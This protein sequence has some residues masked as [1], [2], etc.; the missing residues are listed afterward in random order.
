VEPPGAHLQRAGR[1]ADRPN[2][3]GERNGWVDDRL[4]DRCRGQVAEQPEQREERLLL[5]RRWG[6]WS[7]ELE[8]CAGRG[9]GPAI[10]AGPA[11]GGAPDLLGPD[12]FTFA[13]G[14]RGQEP[15]EVAQPVAAVAAGVDPVVPQAAGVT[16]G[17]DR[18]RVDAQ[19]VCGARDGQRRVDGPRA[20]R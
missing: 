9:S 10:P 2:R 12:G 8:L 5:G 20:E 1:V 13:A 18:V 11:T 14:K 19:D 6:G 16:P 3:A 15:L 17:T 4:A 7:G